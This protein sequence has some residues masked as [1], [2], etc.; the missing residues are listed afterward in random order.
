VGVAQAPSSS[1]HPDGKPENV[2]AE[3]WQIFVLANQARA[4]AGVST[5]VWNQPLADA[6]PK[7][8]VRMSTEGRLAHR[9]NGEQDMSGRVGEAGA[10][11]SFIAENLAVGSAPADIHQQWIDSVDTHA[12]LLNP[13]V[14]SVGVAVV[15]LHGMLYAV[16]DYAHIVPVLTQVQVEAAVAGLLRAHGLGIAQDTTDAR[17]LCAGRT[18]V[19]VQP[20]FVLIWQ[21]SDLTQ[22]PDDLVKILP[23]AHFRKAAVGNCPPVDGNF[24]QYRVAALFYSTGVG[25]Y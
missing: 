11:F 6:A 22:L 8:C 20:S 19:S 3:A 2:R 5:L 15:Q 9:Y 21:S 24:S 10:R 13:D 23:Q 4:A 14:D 1:P 17:G 25:V 16:A 7:H 12:V 18:M